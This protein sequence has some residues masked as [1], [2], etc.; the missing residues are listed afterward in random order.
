MKVYPLLDL[1][2]SLN[3]PQQYRY[4]RIALKYVSETFTLTRLTS[5]KEEQKRGKNLNTF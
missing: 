2:V 3:V 1:F 5:N 4:L